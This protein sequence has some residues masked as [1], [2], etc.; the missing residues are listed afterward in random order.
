MTRRLLALGELV[1]RPQALE[2]AS[3][4]SSFAGLVRQLRVVGIHVDFAMA[5]EDSE[6]QRAIHDRQDDQ[7]IAF[8]SGSRRRRLRRTINCRSHLRGSVRLARSCIRP[9]GQEPRRRQENDEDQARQ[10]RRLARESSRFSAGIA[11]S[12][13]ASSTNSEKAKAHGARRNRS[14]MAR[15][16]KSAE[17]CPSTA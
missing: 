6:V 9:A 4:T 8:G 1:R 3:Q 10:P 7:I 2:L 11:E 15:R 16:E 12:T 17:A 13:R 5:V 14:L